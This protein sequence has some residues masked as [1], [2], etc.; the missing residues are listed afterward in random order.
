MAS[1][2]KHINVVDEKPVKLATKKH[3][4]KVEITF[5]PEQCEYITGWSHFPMDSKEHIHS[6]MT[7]L[8]EALKNPSNRLAMALQVDIADRMR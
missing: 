1:K 6:F 3:G 8:V 7:A 4:I 5:T 2:R